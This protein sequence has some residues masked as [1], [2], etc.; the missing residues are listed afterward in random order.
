MANT[1][2]FV[3]KYLVG[4]DG[5]ENSIKNPEKVSFKPVDLLDDLAFIY[6][7]LSQIE[8]FCRAVVKD[9]RSFKPEYIN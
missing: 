1:L 9:D 2:N 6:T 3:L 8:F 4:P 5:S 7:N